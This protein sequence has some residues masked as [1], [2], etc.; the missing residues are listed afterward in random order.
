MSR[1]SLSRN[2]LFGF[3]GWAIPLGFSF[4]LTP[5]IVRGLGPD[6]YGL[7]ILIV[8]F[9]GYFATFNFNV[10]RSITRLVSVY[11]AE[12]RMQRIGEVLSAAIV[13]Y[14]G[15]GSIGAMLLSTNARWLVANIL[16][17][18]LDMREAAVLSVYFASIGLVFTLL[19]QVFS[20]VSQALQRFDLYGWVMIVSGGATIGGNAIFIILGNGI[21]AIVIWNAAMNLATCTAFYVIARKLLPS[22]RLVCAVRKSAI[23]ELLKFGGA[24]T[25]YQLLGNTIVVFERSWITRILGSAAVTYYVLPMTISTYVHSLVSSFTL[26]IFPLTSEADA[27]GEKTRLYA[28]YLK[29]MKY[30]GGVV[31]FVTTTLFIGSWHFMMN[32]M[33]LEFANKS[34]GLLRLHAV[35][36]GLMS[37]MVVPWQIADGLGV[38]RLNVN[39]SV[40]WFLFPVLF[41]VWLTPSMGAKAFVWGR[42]ASMIGIP[43]YLYFINKKLANNSFSQECKTALPSFVL[44]SLVMMIVQQLLFRSL[45]NGWLYFCAAVALSGIT[46]LTMLFITGYLNREDYKIIKRIF[47]RE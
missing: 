17:V 26:A 6:A 2:V 28:I 19:S 24:V 31:I 8:T 7:Y 33:G 29:A 36:F 18:G 9:V 32:W 38:P 13:L 15:I 41:G 25:A 30:V 3:L 20:A 27:M 37:M 22:T 1:V 34:A 35:V 45:A 4:F 21:V 46:F 23:V 47:Q 42:L 16:N 43:F 44:S 39:L 5:L 12:G 14:I 10:G 11:K 40:C